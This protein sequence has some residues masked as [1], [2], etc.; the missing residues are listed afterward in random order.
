MLFRSRFLFVPLP[1]RVVPVPAEDTDDDLEQAAKAQAELA[2]ICETVYRMPRQSLTLSRKARAAF[3][4]Y[5]Q[6]TQEQ[7]KAAQLGAQGALLGKA[8]GKVLR[9]AGLMHL[10]S[11]AAGEYGKEPRVLDE[12]TINVAARLVDHLNGWTMGLHQSVADGQTDEIGRA[13]V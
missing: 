10:I 3:V 7:I 8:A 4:A 5:E 6:R 9:I 12:A 1:E 13:H 11:V 2:A